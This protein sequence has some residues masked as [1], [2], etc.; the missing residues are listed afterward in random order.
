MIRHNGQTCLSK[1]QVDACENGYSAKSYRKINM[2][3]I[4]REQFDESKIER[5]QQGE[6]LHEIAHQTATDFVQQQVPR[7]CVEGRDN[8]E[9]RNEFSTTG[10][11]SQWQPIRG[12]RPNKHM[13]NEQED[14]ELKVKLN[15]FAKNQIPRY[16]AQYQKEQQQSTWEPEQSNVSEQIRSTWKQLSLHRMM[17]MTE[18]EHQQINKELRRMLTKKPEVAEWVFQYEKELPAIYQKLVVGLRQFMLQPYSVENERVVK[19]LSHQITNL[20]N[21]VWTYIV[22]QVIVEH[23][24]SKHQQQDFTAPELEQIVSRVWSAASKELHNWEIER[25]EETLKNFL[26]Q[27]KENKPELHQNMFN[28]FKHHGLNED[29]TR[30]ISHKLLKLVISSF[31]ISNP[32]HSNKFESTEQR[33]HQWSIFNDEQL[34]EAEQNLRDAVKRDWSDFERVQTRKQQKQQQNNWEDEDQF[35]DEEYSEEQYNQEKK[36]STGLGN[37]FGKLNV[38]YQRF[39]NNIR[40]NKY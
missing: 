15:R 23:E 6:K 24:Q 32:E 29:E 40:K 13:I 35:D 17:R 12:A 30:T 14:D 39:A 20:A 19:M 22:K 25:T 31:L 28:V 33:D 36:G 2:P 21:R 18:K 1:N 34:Q 26:H 10:R 27:L 7:A 16:Q 11:R 3:V 8:D 37:L 38:A 4:C 9:N 5:A